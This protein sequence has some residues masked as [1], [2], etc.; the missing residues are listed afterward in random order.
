MKMPK[1]WVAT[2]QS[3]KS[4]ASNAKL[5]AKKQIKARIDMSEDIAGKGLCPECG[6]PMT[7]VF[8]N[9]IPC[10][11]CFEDRIVLPIADSEISK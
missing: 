5:S 1:S 7:H 10:L 4:I 6:K 9:T 3:T 2:Q 11:C 8:A